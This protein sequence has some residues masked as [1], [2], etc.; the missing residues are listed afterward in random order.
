LKKPVVVSSDNVPDNS[1]TTDKL[2]DASVTDEKLGLT[3]IYGSNLGSAFSGL[4]ER[5]PNTVYQNT[6]GK[7][8]MVIADI[9][10]EISASG[11]DCGGTVY[12][13]DIDGDTNIIFN[14]GSETGFI[15][16]AST[17]DFPIMFIVPPGFFYQVVNFN[18]SIPVGMASWYEVLL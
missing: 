5:V 17:F 12:C 7:M 11:G 8:L 10:C 1:I 15:N 6:T 4:F 9:E 2:V 18:N 16:E 3:G 13:D 14:V